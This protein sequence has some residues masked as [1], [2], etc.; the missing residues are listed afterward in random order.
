MADIDAKRMLEFFSRIED[1]QHSFAGR[2][3]ARLFELSPDVEQLFKSVGMEMQGK[4]VIQALGI[5][6]RS[7]ENEEDFATIFRSLGRRHARA[8]HLL[9]RPTFRVDK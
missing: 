3:Y 9:G 7:H 2:F 4:M 1:E 8:V 5:G 6:I